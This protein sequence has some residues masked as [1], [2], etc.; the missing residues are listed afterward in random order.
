MS[1]PLRV[2]GQEGVPIEGGNCSGVL[3]LSCFYGAECLP[4]VNST[5]VVVIDFVYEFC[6]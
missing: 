1:C 3:S 6:I 2:F 5:A 4:D